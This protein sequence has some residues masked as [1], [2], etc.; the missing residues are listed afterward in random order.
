[1]MLLDPNKI[2]PNVIPQMKLFHVQAVAGKPLADPISAWCRRETPMIYG[3][4]T[5]G[6]VPLAEP[7][8]M[9]SLVGVLYSPSV[10]VMDDGT[11]SKQPV[12]QNVSG[13]IPGNVRVS[14]GSPDSRR[15]EM[16]RVVPKG[17]K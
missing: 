2:L 11:A 9:L 3:V 1:M 16:Q 10:E 15:G 6:T 7:G 4:V 5:L 13:E 14:D 8:G 12:S 17:S